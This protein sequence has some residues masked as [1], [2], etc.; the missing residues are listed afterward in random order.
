MILLLEMRIPIV[1]SMYNLPEMI[2][3]K[4]S[5]ELSRSGYEDRQDIISRYLFKVPDNQWHLFGWKPNVSWIATRGISVL[6]LN[7]PRYNHI[8]LRISPLPLL[9]PLN[10]SLRLTSSF[11][12]YYSYYL[13]SAACV[14]L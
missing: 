13:R 6:N 5:I 1:F 12:Y 2:I 10:P 4:I 14:F 8:L 3:Y 9:F 11:S 7:V